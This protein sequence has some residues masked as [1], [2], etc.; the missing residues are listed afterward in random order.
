MVTAHNGRNGEAGQLSAKNTHAG[1]VVGDNW[2]LT[3]VAHV[4]PLGRVCPIQVRYML[5]PTRLGHS[6]ALRQI[7]AALRRC[8]LDL[9]KEGIETNRFFLCLPPW[10]G[11]GQEASVRMSMNQDR[12]V[13]RR[14]GVVSGRHVRELEQRLCA[15]GETDSHIVSDILP[16]YFEMSER[17][18]VPDPV[19]SLSDEL[20]LKAYVLRAELGTVQGILDGLKKMNVV[21]DVMMSSCRA[22]SD[23]LSE[24]DRESGVVLVDVSTR[25]TTCTAYAGGNMID[26]AYVAQGSDHVLKAAA[27]GLHLAPRDLAD[28]VSENRDELLSISCGEAVR[29]LPLFG[30]DGGFRT[31]CELDR[32]ARAPCGG[33]FQS[34]RDFVDGVARD[35]GCRLGKLVFA[36]DEC[37][38]LHTL[39]ALAEER[40]AVECAWGLPKAVYGKDC[41]GV[42]GYARMVGLMRQA[43]LSPLVTP[44]YLG[45]YNE[46]FIR[47]LTRGGTR[48]VRSSCESVVGA[49][50]RLVARIAPAATRIVRAWR[51]AAKEGAKKHE[52]GVKV[53]WPRLARPDRAARPSSLF[54]SRR[55]IRPAWFF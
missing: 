24:S 38:T 22:S 49:A 29:L 7:Q 44:L 20:E 41:T 13:F 18:R 11:D 34:I 43:A 55:G 2:V 47:K 40:M 32:A 53:A 9:W 52:A 28:Y 46:S 37:L 39:K 33:L 8:W 10:I 6:P 3:A 23:V 35:R 25:G 54:G 4:D 19:E 48:F 5:I 15:E 51:T 14:R 26:T 31:L 27:E 50:D 1:A 12:T 45:R 30:R 17:R 21:V 36:G 42:P 16:H